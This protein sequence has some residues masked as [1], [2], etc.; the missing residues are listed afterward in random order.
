M[1]DMSTVFPQ[2]G[3]YVSQKLRGPIVN[4]ALRLV[5]LTMWLIPVNTRRYG[6]FG[7]VD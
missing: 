1:R 5:L 2:F 7:F 6:N 4:L 3:N